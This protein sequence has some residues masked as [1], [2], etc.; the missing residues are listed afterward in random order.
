MLDKELLSSCEMPQ[1]VAIIMDGNGRWAK[2]KGWQRLKGHEAG[3][4]SVREVV[5]ACAEWGIPNLTLYAFSKENWLRPQ[6]EIDGLMSFLK[7]FLRSELQLLID[8]QVSLKGLGQLEDLPNDVREVLENI[9]E[10][11]SHL[12]GLKLRLALSYGGRQEITESVKKIA[13]AINAGELEPLDVDQNTVKSYLFDPEM[14]DPDLIIRT[15][16][17]HRLSNFLLWQASYSE[18]YFSEKLWPDFRKK[19]FLNALVSFSGR[20]RKFGRVVEHG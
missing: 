15:A 12:E 9:E 2:T 20:H 3:V 4:Q 13:L 7:Q 11:T 16:N 18:L 17:E 19:D 6:Q 8:N 14:P 1:H 10:Q 5:T